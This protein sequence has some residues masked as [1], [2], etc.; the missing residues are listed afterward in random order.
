MPAKTAKSAPK[1]RRA[2][3]R[4]AI[5]AAAGRLFAKV[6]YSECDMEAIAAKLGVAKG[7]LYLHFESK[8]ALFSACVD[9]ALARSRDAMSKASDDEPDLLQRP[10]L[11]IRAYLA[12]FDKYPH[13]VELVLQERAIFKSRR[14][15]SYFK[16]RNINRTKWREVWQAL[17]EQK[18]IRGDL[19]V[20]RILDVVGNVMYGAIFT[21][22]FVGKS[23]STEEQFDVIW[24]VLTKGLVR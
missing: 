4:D 11:A 6:G 20:D 22:Y 16:N 15:P 12:F 9:D 24:K 18:R 8:E 2:T 3:S 21:N 10:A 7:T 5:L 19:P 1:R 17:I 13:F 23:I 14:P